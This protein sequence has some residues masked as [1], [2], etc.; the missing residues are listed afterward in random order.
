[1][2]KRDAN[3][4]KLL[5][6]PEKSKHEAFR[7][8]CP[9]I[10]AYTLLFRECKTVDFDPLLPSSYQNGDLPRC[11]CLQ[12]EESKLWYSY[13]VCLT[14]MLTPTHATLKSYGAGILGQEKLKDGPTS[15]ESKRVGQQ[16]YSH[17]HQHYFPLK[18]RTC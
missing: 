2:I 10:R 17:F 18:N 6:S 11:N 16:V 4:S 8:S 13:L 12:E 1:M 15:N 7:G 5:V 14:S 3:S 9:P